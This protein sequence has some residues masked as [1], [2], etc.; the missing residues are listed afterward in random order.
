L[1]ILTIKYSLYPKMLAFLCFIKVKRLQ[2]GRCSFSSKTQR[3]A[4][5][6]WNIWK[7]RNNKVF[8]RTRFP[9]PACCGGHALGMPHPRPG[10]HQTTG[11]VSPIYRKEWP[12][13]RR[14]GYSQH[15]IFKPK[16]SDVWGTQPPRLLRVSEWFACQHMAHFTGIALKH[17]SMPE[18]VRSRHDT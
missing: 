6:L 5:V 17:D 4:A 16:T 11:W 3:N 7:N 10:R 12:T 18:L 2:H 15:S 1:R 13:T 9:L 8:K 14:E